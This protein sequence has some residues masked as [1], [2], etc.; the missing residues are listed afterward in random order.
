MK[1]KGFNRDDD[2]KHIPE[3]ELMIAR[4]N[5]NLSFGD[6]EYLLKPLL[7]ILNG[8]NIIDCFFYRVENNKLYCCFK[9]SA[10]SDF[11]RKILYLISEI[12]SET[13]FYSDDEVSPNA[14]RLEYWP[15]NENLNYLQELYN[16][17]IN[18]RIIV[19]ECDINDSLMIM[20][21]TIMLANM[22]QMQDPLSL[23]VNQGKDIYSA[24][25][26]ARHD[27]YLEAGSTE[28]NW[29]QL[30]V[31]LSRNNPLRDNFYAPT[32]K[33]AN[34]NT[35]IVCDNIIAATLVGCENKTFL[36]FKLDEEDLVTVIEEYMADI[37]LEVKNTLLKILNP[38]ARLL[39]EKDASQ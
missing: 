27:N 23:P 3:N 8:K 5:F 28:Q 15:L 7:E 24:E 20:G 19:F 4:D 6:I 10:L 36:T 9:Q 14:D 11:N 34:I 31:V 39:L 18:K 29:F 33:V 2:I 16:R 26:L 21:G 35:P 30:T 37:S 22:F 1:L 12:Y 13:F 32:L 17:C 25:E 38:S